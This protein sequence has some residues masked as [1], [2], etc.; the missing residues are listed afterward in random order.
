MIDPKQE[1]SEVGM[2]WPD[3]SMF[4]ADFF[5]GPGHQ[6][7]E[8]PEVGRFDAEDTDQNESS[9]EKHLSLEELTPEPDSNLGCSTSTKVGS[10][11]FILRA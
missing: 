10:R 1:L 11:S 6:S 5:A 9:E 4:E 7:Y 3:G 2:L 8:W